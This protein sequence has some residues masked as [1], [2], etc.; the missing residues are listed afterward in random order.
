MSQHRIL[1]NVWYTPLSLL[2]KIS[3]GKVILSISS[4][5]YMQQVEKL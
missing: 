3:E 4:E 2:Y 5:N 1:M